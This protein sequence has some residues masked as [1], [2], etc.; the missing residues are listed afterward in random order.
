MESITAAE[1]GRRASSSGGGPPAGRGRAAFLD[2]I[3][4]RIVQSPR[5]IV[6]GDVC[7]STRIRTFSLKPP[8]ECVRRVFRPR[9]DGRF[10]RRRRRRHRVSFF[11]PSY[12]LLLLYINVFFFPFFQIAFQ[13]AFSRFI[14]AARHGNNN[15][16]DDAAAP[17][18]SAAADVIII[19]YVTLS[20]RESARTPN[21]HRPTVFLWIFS[22]FFFFF[23]YSRFFFLHF[24]A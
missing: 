16:D 19:Y 23:Q 9:I 11:S 8:R 1:A 22:G 10:F 20:S 24:F 2:E 7:I 21:D 17:R 4:A 13:N 6:F 14:S 3:F 18:G 5:R 15:D 12:L